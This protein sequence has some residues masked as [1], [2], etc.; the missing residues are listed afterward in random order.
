MDTTTLTA[1]GN[2]YGFE[3][4][5]SRSFKALASK[6]DLLFTIS[7]SGNSKN[8]YNVLKESKKMKIFSIS[9]LGKKSGSCKNL[10]NLEIKVNSKTTARI[11]ETHIF[12]IHHILESVEDLLIKNAK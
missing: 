8:V 4:I 6:G 5:F 3:Y 9:L 2:D 7:T 12:I 11:Q 10:S 1:C